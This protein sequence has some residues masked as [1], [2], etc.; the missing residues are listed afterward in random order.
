MLLQ[1]NTSQL[2]CR[3]ATTNHV[4]D[5]SDNEYILRL[6]I[7]KLL[8]KQREMQVREFES[9]S[10]RALVGTQ[11]NTARWNLADETCRTAPLCEDWIYTL[12]IR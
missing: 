6:E 9:F 2:N 8:Q 11:K 5:M 4:H 3:L 10:I 1:C 7:A 12:L